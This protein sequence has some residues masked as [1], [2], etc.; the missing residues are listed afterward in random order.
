MKYIV[1]AFFVF[2]L[3]FAGCSGDS[4]QESE[5]PGPVTRIEGKKDVVVS[6]QLQQMRR[7]DELGDG[8][9]FQIDINS[10]GEQTA[11]YTTQW[12][13]ADQ[14]NF[15]NRG[16]AKLTLFSNPPGGDDMPV[17]RMVVK[18]DTQSLEEY[19][20]QT[21]ELANVNFREE[22]GQGLETIKG[23]GSIIIEAIVDEMVQGTFDVTLE[24]GD[25][26]TGSF[27]A[28]FNMVEED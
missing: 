3:L 26:L 16:N 13:Y 27:K 11:A 6:E 21:L 2:A 24:N 19:I 22:K 7:D 23:E 28:V 4:G 17:L 9:M 8:G 5:E 14:R 18:L 20:G 12:G 25:N 10:N 15:R 1:A